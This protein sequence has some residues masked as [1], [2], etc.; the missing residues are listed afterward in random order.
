MSLKN[1]QTKI[2]NKRISKKIV[3]NEIVM[4]IC[5]VA[6]NQLNDICDKLRH[7]LTHPPTLAFSVGISPSAEAKGNTAQ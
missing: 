5:L 1:C 2:L 3:K 7:Q 4:D 6:F